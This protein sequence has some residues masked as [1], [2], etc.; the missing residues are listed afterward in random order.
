MQGVPVWRKVSTTAACSKSYAPMNRCTAWVIALTA[1]TCTSLVKPSIT[2]LNWD[3]QFSCSTNTQQV[4][5]TNWMMTAS[6]A[7]LLVNNVFVDL[8]IGWLDSTKGIWCLTVWKRAWGLYDFAFQLMLYGFFLSAVLKFIQTSKIPN[9]PA[10]PNIFQ[11]KDYG[12]PFWI[13]ICIFQQGTDKLF[14]Y[15][16]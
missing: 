4:W 12:S 15:K 13:W 1:L 14:K 7:H 8:F 2:Y 5:M 11:C 6:P 9:C 10:F 16:R 3:D